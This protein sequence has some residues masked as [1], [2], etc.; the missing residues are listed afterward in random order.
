MRIRAI[1]SIHSDR[2]IH[3]PVAGVVAFAALTAAGSCIAIPLPFTPVPLTL[4]TLFVLLAGVTLGP[5]LGMA[6]MVFYVLLGTVG[7]QVFAEQHWGLQT[8]CGA[9]GGY[10]LGFV[11]AQPAIGY[12]TRR[13]RGTWR[14]LLLAT[15]AGEAILLT[16]GVVWLAFAL[17]LDAQTALALGLW[18]FLP[19]DALKIALAVGAARVALPQARRLLN[20]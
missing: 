9:T 13:G 4:Q 2:C 20:G 3:A 19:G 5:G 8:I 14:D 7:Y 10:L 6:S 15:L 18:P 12:L 17:G 16:C 11:L 1:W